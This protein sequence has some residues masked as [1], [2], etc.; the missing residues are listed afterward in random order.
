MPQTRHNPVRKDSDGETD[1]VPM[2]NSN[3]NHAPSTSKQTEEVMTKKKTK[4]VKATEVKGTKAHF[5]ED[6]ETVNMHVTGHITSDGEIN[7][8]DESEEDEPEAQSNDDTQ[9]RHDP[10]SEHSTIESESEDED[11]EELRRQH[12]K[13][14]KL[15]K[16]ERRE[17]M[18]KKIDSLTTSLKVMQDFMTKRGF[19][20]DDEDG[21]K[22]GHGKRSKLSTG[23]ESDSDEA[24]SDTTIYRGAVRK[25]NES[26]YSGK[27]QVMVD[28]EI[29]F[30]RSNRDSS[31]SDDKMA[32]TSDEL[33]ELDEN[34]RFIAECAAA[35]DNLKRHNEAEQLARPGTSMDE[36][37]RIIRQNEA[38]KARLYAAPGNSN[39][40]DNCTN[41]VT[42]SIDD[43]Y[44]VIGNHVDYVTQQKIVAGEYIDFARLLPKQRFVEDEN[45]LEIVS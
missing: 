19:L 33:M 11:V 29:S 4:A 35:A 45:K 44:L 3:S 10:M 13:K 40:P 39:M 20:E 28:P 41:M 32:D 42:G 9:S 34:D 22:R 12:K 24:D 5:T 37:E 21:R 26:N 31:S 30:K 15:M 25:D 38:N 18:E 6:D 16:K 43:N 8:G 36:G 2:E 7:S 1:T 27:K 14:K 23:K 17:S